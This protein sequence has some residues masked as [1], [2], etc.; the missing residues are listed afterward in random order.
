MKV[1]LDTNVLAY[2]EGVNGVARQNAAIRGCQ[3]RLL[4][5]CNGMAIGVFCLSHGLAQREGG[6]LSRLVRDL[7]ACCCTSSAGTMARGAVSAQ[8]LT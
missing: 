8:G 5:S 1:A 7:P 6:P 2:V 4:V 3:S